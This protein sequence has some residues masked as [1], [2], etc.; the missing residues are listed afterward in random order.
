MSFAVGR[1][2]ILVMTTVALAFVAATVYTQVLERRIDGHVRRIADDAMPSVRYAADAR[3]ELYAIEDAAENYL[4]IKGE[5][6]DGE[7]WAA[8]VQHRR[9]VDSL[10]ASYQS[11][12]MFAGEPELAA[13]ADRRLQELDR[14]LLA[15]R[16]A[17]TSLERHGAYRRL[18]EAVM[19]SDDALRRVVELNAD[20]GA[21]LAREIGR[22]RQRNAML[23]FAF[24]AVALALAIAATVA[25]VAEMRRSTRSLEV[26]RESAE[27]R[28]AE[29]EDRAFELEQFAGR[30][31]HDVLSPLGG[32]GL[33]LQSIARRPLDERSREMA[34]RGRASLE[35]VRRIVDDLLAF[36]R[37]GGPP[38]GGMSAD[39][40]P[41]VFDVV[42]GL[43][44]SAEAERVEV[45]IEPFEPFR[46]AC[47][48]GVL[49]SVL[50][51]L[52]GNA[53]KHMGAQPVRRVRV[54]VEHLEE[55]TRFEVEDTGPGI[56]SEL[57]D[58][59][60][61]PFVRAAAPGRPGLGL[62]LAT[63]KRLVVRHGGRVGYRSTPGRGSRFWVELP[64]AM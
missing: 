28:A 33:A 24:Y 16:L 56:P 52:I 42:E 17:R 47:A 37:A 64:R 38:S 57:G 36:A 58:T 23:A 32:V 35:R 50:T 30:V 21:S 9:R 40:G 22:S 41:I 59:V 46:V 53:I 12:P 39:V 54:R 25:T 31:A 48:P 11:E 4:G 6:P 8:V 49:T 60:F 10:W 55:M 13:A 63:V 29:F 27:R 34:A 44:A 15:I 3:S 26:R 45:V 2:Q 18:H 20:S 19:Q 1:L 51:N 61:E 7:A 43:H 62:G 14:S 5:P